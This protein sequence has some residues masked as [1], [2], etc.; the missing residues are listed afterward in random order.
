MK[1]SLFK[2]IGCS[3][4]AAASLTSFAGPFNRAD[5]PASAVWVIHVDCDILRPTGIGQYLM[6]ELSKPEVQDKF[7]A[8][9]S[10][11]SFDPRKQL[12]GLTLYSTSSAPEDGVLLLYADFDPDRLVTLARAANGYGSVTNNSH[13]IHNW[14]DDKK[15]AK[16][17]VKP[18]VYAA[19]VGSRAV[20]FGQRQSTIAKTLEAIDQVS[21]NLSTSQSFTDMGSASDT[22]FLQAAANKLDLPGSDPNAAL[23]RLAKML[24]LQISEVQQQ[25]T[26]SLSLQANDEE[27]AGQM[28]SVANG[29]LSLVKLQQ[30]KPDAAKL[31]EALSIKQNGP[32]VVATL[33]LSSQDAVNMLKA[34]AAKKAEKSAAKETQ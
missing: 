32:S 33:A 24:R 11:F 6:T 7:A 28:A 26:A 23:F 13:V 8:F 25:L 17:G 2:L 1:S 16:D 34:D 19:I 12:H 4:L 14:I 18:R 5:V 21:P 27:V 29:L 10:I 20:V 22:S 30:D 31:A 9:Q 3:A 15:R